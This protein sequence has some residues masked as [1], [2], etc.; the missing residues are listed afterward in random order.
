M[1]S[2]YTER[3][4]NPNKVLSST[5]LDSIEMPIFLGVVFQLLLN[6]QWLNQ[7]ICHLSGFN[8][9]S[10]V[11]E[12]WLGLNWNTWVKH[13]IM[14]LVHSASRDTFSVVVC[15]LVTCLIE[16]YQPL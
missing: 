10:V 6:V 3:Q 12:W 4:N 5:A 11:G 8:L 16:W 1:N 14:L 9:A 7:D 2:F 13:E 15:I